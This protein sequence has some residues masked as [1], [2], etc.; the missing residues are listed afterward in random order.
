VQRL[1]RDSVSIRV[2]SRNKVE[3][4]PSCFSGYDTEFVYGD[5]SD[6]RFIED[7][8]IGVHQVVHLISSLSPSSPVHEGKNELV[9]TIFPTIQLVESCAK[10]GVK[11][12]IYVSSGGTVYGNQPESPIQED[13]SME[14]VSI[15]G[16]SKKITENYVRFCACKVNVSATILRVANPFGPG[17]DPKRR[18]GIVAVAMDCLLKKQ[19]FDI[20]GDGSA[21]RDYLFV[22]DVSDA[23]VR[24]LIADI[25][26][27]FNVSSGIGLSIIEILDLIESVTGLSLEKRWL[28]PRVTDVASNV[29]SNALARDVLGWSPTTDVKSGIERTWGWIQGESKNAIGE[30]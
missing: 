15:Y 30:A 6:S 11:R 26:G 9:S 28:P 29:L 1:T 23:I 24:A 7:A 10:A 5:F 3:L 22:E 19:V 27:T 13:A 12:L 16:L 14:P 8:L 17:Q 4:R 18:Q 21:I 25:H 20:V 2:L